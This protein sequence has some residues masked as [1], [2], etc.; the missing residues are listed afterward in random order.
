MC[1]KYI[2]TVSNLFLLFNSNCR[3]CSYASPIILL[4]SASIKLANFLLYIFLF[5]YKKK[6]IGHYALKYNE[7]ELMVILFSIKSIINLNYRFS[8]PTRSC[9]SRPIQIIN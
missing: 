3:V 1:K 5:F 7:Q 2:H 8:V 4:T 9:I 6:G